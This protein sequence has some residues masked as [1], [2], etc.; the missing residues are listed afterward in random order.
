MSKSKYRSKNPSE[1]N[2]YGP[3]WFRRMFMNISVRRKSRALEHAVVHGA[4]IEAIMWPI[5][6]KPKE[7][8][9]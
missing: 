5:G 9:L 6:N 7:W 4:D 1:K 8:W 3:S 2:P